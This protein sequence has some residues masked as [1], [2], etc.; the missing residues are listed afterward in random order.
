MT[1][2]RGTERGIGRARLNHPASVAFAFPPRHWRYLVALPALLVL[3]FAAI[4]TVWASATTTPGPS[5]GSPSAE[6]TP[7]DLTTGQ[8]FVVRGGAFPPGSQVQVATCSFAVPASGSGCDDATATTADVSP[9]GELALRTSVG[10]PS[11]PCPCVVRLSTIDRVV[12]LALSINLNSVAGPD[13]ASISRQSA[14]ARGQVRISD[15]QLSE[16]RS[17]L[18]SFGASRDAVLTFTVEN[19]G[20]ARIDNPH[21]LLAF[22]KDGEVSDALA[23]PE[24]GA[25]A[26][27]EARTVRVPVPMDSFSFGS[28]RVT[29]HITGLTNPVDFSATTNAYPWGLIAVAV[30]AVA[31][32]AAGLSAAVLA[33]KARQR[34]ANRAPLLALPAPTRALGAGMPALPAGP[35]RRPLVMAASRI[36]GDDPDSM[37][38][39]TIAELLVDVIPS[40]RASL[41]AAPPNA[42]SAPQV[43]ARLAR[44]VATATAD[45]LVRLRPLTP[46]ERLAV[47]AHLRTELGYYLSIQNSALSGHARVVSAG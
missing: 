35:A 6:I 4:P 31:V 18:S 22:G 40:L 28:Y 15:A 9:S 20:S 7:V 2:Q 32:I 27:G 47:E 43:V 8:T 23:A 44:E 10:H 46:E 13:A 33:R 42:V 38:E 16:R 37:L 29:G 1:A 45:A 25:L 3:A 24:I 14:Q 36:P 12:A 11:T 34:Q 21:L 30:I 41:A 26:P 39:N 17:W 19:T 5:T